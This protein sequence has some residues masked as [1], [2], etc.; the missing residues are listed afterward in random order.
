MTLTQTELQGLFEYDPL[1]GVLTWKEKRSNMTK[2]SVA[3]CLH[4]SGYM[5]VTIN[6]KTYKLHRIIWIYMFNVIPDEFYIDHINGNKV[7]NRL[8]NLRLATNHQNQQNRPAPKN[9]SSGY[10]GVNWHKQMNKWMARI[11][12]NKQRKIIG[13]FDT[14]EDAYAAYKLEA[15]K[16]FTHLD[17]LP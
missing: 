3:G 6:S 12:H 4:K 15:Q 14:P 11:C 10:R 8:Q 17:R 2:G 5:V 1:S 7:D 9:S 16:L 13:Y